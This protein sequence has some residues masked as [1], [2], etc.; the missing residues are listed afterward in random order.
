MHVEGIGLLRQVVAAI[1]AD[2]ERDA[3]EDPLVGVDRLL[4]GIDEDLI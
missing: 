3:G 4:P 2:D 1:G